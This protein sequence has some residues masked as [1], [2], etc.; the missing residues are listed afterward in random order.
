MHLVD[1]GETVTW[2]GKPMVGL[3]VTF[4][5]ATATCAACLD[6][7]SAAF[8]VASEELRSIP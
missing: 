2:C 8:G 4:H 3:P 6:A 7:L 5:T 1:I